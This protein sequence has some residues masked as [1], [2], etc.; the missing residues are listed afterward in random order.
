MRSIV[1]ITA[2]LMALTSSLR[3]DSEPVSARQYQPELAKLVASYLTYY[4]YS[5]AMVD[6]QVAERALDLYLQ[7]LDYNRL[8]LLAS[9][10]DEFKQFVD[11]LDD[12]LRGARYQIEKPFDIFNRYRERVVQR[13]DVILKLVDHP[14]D[15]SVKESMTIDRSEEP[16]AKSED[17]LNELWRLRIKEQALRYRLN[18]KDDEKIRELLRKRYERTVKNLEDFDSADVLENYLSAVAHAFD[19]HSSYLKPATKDNFDIDFGH[20]LEGIG[21]T[22]RTEGEYTI[23][24]DLIPGGP[25]ALS[26]SVM[27]NDKIVAVAQDGEEPVDVI[28]MRIDRVVKQIRG[29]KGTT[30]H[31]HLI[32]AEAIDESE[33]KIVTLVRDKVMITAEDVTQEVREV[34][35]PDGQSQRFGVVTIP[36]FYLDSQARA[37][38]EPNYKSVSRDVRKAIQELEKEQIDGMLI[39][40]RNNPGGSLDE[41]V[42]L[43]GLFIKE[44]PVVQI[45]S[46]NGHLEVLED[47]NEEVVYDGPLVVM[48]NLFSASASEIF[49][50]A[51]QDYGRGLVIGDSSTHGK[52][53]VQNVIALDSSLARVIDKPLTD[54]IA[55][56]LKLTTHK[57]YRISG[58]STQRRGVAPDIALPSLYDRYE[59]GE[60]HLDYALV[61]DEIERV[62]HE[63]YG[64]VD[65]SLDVLRQISAKRVS[66]NP[67][68][69]YL[70]EDFETW[71]NKK[72]ANR[73]SLNE[74][75]RRKEKELLD[76][77]EAT[78]KAE[79]QS[80]LK[81][82]PIDKEAAIDDIDVPDFM[83]E[84]AVQVLSDY[85]RIS[86]GKFI[87][88][89]E[90]KKAG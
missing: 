1:L 6:D 11:S 42:A 44:G 27:P 31:L 29:R 59:F 80:R 2:C 34:T 90:L 50:G 61:W 7:S 49:A 82:T 33:V 45:R 66:A 18:G 4:H 75:E 9:D 23:V 77:I 72:K 30:V 20:S 46:R 38:G 71:L 81:V 41:A 39:D 79:R 15:Y 53:T 32:P 3:A 10:V 24:V 63:S 68:F 47:E 62:A 55:G 60:E 73:V 88:A 65:S 40:L 69:Q 54:R 35:S 84:E 25:A 26:G 21:A 70:R 76:Q 78:R 58:S 57:F 56:A 85:Y 83:L 51:I 48:T 37:Q 74:T 64:L 28:D 19:P 87:A 89:A 36:S 67:E 17:E 22:L 13:M 12:D 43:T 16:W 86:H 5:K 52:G 14:F 8:F